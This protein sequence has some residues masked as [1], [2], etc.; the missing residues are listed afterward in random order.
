MFGIE[1][2]IIKW[3]LDQQGKSGFRNYTLPFNKEYINHKIAILDSN[4]PERTGKNLEYLVAY[5]FMTV[6]GFKV[7]H[8]ALFKIGE[9]DIMVSNQNPSGQPLKWID[10]YIL[11]ECKDWNAPVGVPQ[12]G[13]HLTK[14]LLSHTKVGII[15]SRK[16]ISGRGGRA[17]A[18]RQQLLAYSQ[19][20]FVVLDILYTELKYLSSY[21][22]F[23]ELLQG[24]YEELRFSKR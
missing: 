24:K 18:A 11:I 21:S 4:G 9:V 10:D 14:L 15:V 17:H 13:N 6:P 3:V 22:S 2:I 19:S 20:D 5:C 23:L 8:R 7:G 16:G 12:F 1:D